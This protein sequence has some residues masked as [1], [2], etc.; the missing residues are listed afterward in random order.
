VTRTAPGDQ[1]RSVEG[2]VADGGRSNL[3]VA[4]AALA[5]VSCVFPGL[6][7]GA[8]AVQASNDFG[9]TEGT[10][11]WA[12]GVFFLCAAAA[13]VPMGLLAQR[14]GPRRQ[15]T[16][17]LVLTAAVQLAIATAARSFALMLLLLGLGGVLNSSVQT[18]VN[19]ALSRAQLPRLGLAMATKQSAMPAS[20]M[21]GGLAVPAVALTLGW[22]WAYAMGAG[23]AL[24]ALLMVRRFI[25]AG[26]VTSTPKKGWDVVSSPRS[27]ILGMAGVSLL[28]A[29]SAGSIN[30]WT[31]SSGVD[32]GLSEG[33]AGLAL[34]IAAGLGICVRLLSGT[35]LDR[36]DRLPLLPAVFVTMLGVVGFGLLAL[37]VPETHLLGTLL[38]FGAGW[39]WPV[40]TNFSIVNAN[41]DGA[42]AATG[43]TQ[44]GV[45][46]GVF[47]A[48]VATGQIIERTSYTTMWV[49]V[50]VCGALGVAALR[51]LAPQFPR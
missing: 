42:A 3:I 43:V 50:A 39:I 26:L 23:V 45:Y 27:A 40:F 21:L 7:A 30:A 9:V 6:A 32:A 46:V 15:L 33:V 13:A 12:L 35:V 10:Y 18:A 47:L 17:S 2:G 44:M 19:L 20:S 5:T 8:L 22:R 29:F 24:I 34:S 48:P 38:A 41:T 51:V 11:G 4:T 49:V 14:L 16:I 36:T 25:A 37:R 28:L 1:H 31:V